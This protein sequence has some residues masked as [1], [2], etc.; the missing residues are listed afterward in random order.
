MGSVFSVYGLG[1]MA[2]LFSI[3]SSQ[4][5]R[6]KTTISFPSKPTALSVR[7][8]KDE[9]DVETCSIR[10]LVETRVSSVFKDFRPLWWLSKCVYF[11]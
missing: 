10:E 6:Y 7:K 5:P 3:A 1:I 8:G 4:F 9:D 2:A 11:P